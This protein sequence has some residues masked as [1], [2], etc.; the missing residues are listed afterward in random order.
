MRTSTGNL[1][2]SRWR[3]SL[4]MFPMATHSY[5][6]YRLPLFCGIRYRLHKKNTRVDSLPLLPQRE[7]KSPVCCARCRGH[8]RFI[9]LSRN[10]CFP[11]RHVYAVVFSR[12]LPQRVYAPPA[13]AWAC[14]F[15]LA[16]YTT[17]SSKLRYSPHTV[18]YKSIS[19][20]DHHAQ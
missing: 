12:I 18:Y 19:T 20:A 16:I 4:N 15:R 14:A 10:V 3:G 2:Q 1:I 11:P 13:R 8:V 17:I 7:V 6:R 9:P 5:Q